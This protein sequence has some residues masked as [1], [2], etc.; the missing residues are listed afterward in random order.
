MRRAGRQGR[1]GKAPDAFATRY[2]PA[3]VFAGAPRFHSGIG[4]GERPAILRTDE[5]VLTPGQMRQLAPAGG[6]D[7]TVNVMNAPPDTKANVTTSRDANGKQR[8]DIM[9][10]R[11]VDDTA[12]AMVDSGQSSLNSSL[13]RRYGLQP[14]L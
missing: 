7:I 10:Q 6:G 4:P 2:V 9:L 1:R 14:K 3:A 5:S 13:E 11:S 8:I 12:A